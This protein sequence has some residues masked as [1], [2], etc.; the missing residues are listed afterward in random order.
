MAANHQRSIVESAARPRL[1]G[2]ACL[3]LLVALLFQ[4]GLVRTHV[5][6]AQLLAPPGVSASL[7]ASGVSDATSQHV[8]DGG[9][10]SCL[11]CREAAAAGQYMLPG[12]EFI[13]APLQLHRWA[14]PQA[15]IEFALGTPTHGW[16]SR[17]PPR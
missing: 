13:A 1:S 15:A 6:A 2:V 10:G 4:G 5:H 17:A 14:V 16:L 9:S 7:Q 8:P 3:L 11:L 12:A